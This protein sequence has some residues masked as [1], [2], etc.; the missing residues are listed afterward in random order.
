MRI[1]PGSSSDG[2]T[3]QALALALALAFH[4]ASR[5]ASI[6]VPCMHPPQQEKRSFLL[7]WASFWERGFHKRPRHPP[8]SLVSAALCFPGIR[9]QRAPWRIPST[10]PGAGEDAASWPVAFLLPKTPV[11]LQKEAAAAAA[12]ASAGCEGRANPAGAAAVGVQERRQ[13]S[14][15]VRACVVC[16]CVSVSLRARSL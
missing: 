11:Q 1:R 10:R 5:Q 7:I 15:C 4:A 14:L 16:V 9:V 8:D 2:E 12:A 6:A 13:P 3:P